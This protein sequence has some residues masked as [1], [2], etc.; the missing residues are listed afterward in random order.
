MGGTGPGQ[1]TP[2]APASDGTEA[3]AD[4]AA[5]GLDTTLTWAELDELILARRAMSKDGREALRHLAQT[6]L[7]EVLGK[8]NGLTLSDAAVAAQ[9]DEIKRQIVASGEKG[10]FEGFLK[11]K[12]VTLVDFMRLLR[13]GS[14][15]ETLT[16]RALGLKDDERVTG[17]QQQMWMDDALQ[18]RNYQEF[19]PP[20][21]DGIV[22]QCADVVIMQDEFFDYLHLRLPEEAL[23][24]D[25]WQLL[26]AKRMRARMPD[27][28][29]EKLAKAV[30]DELQR[31]RDETKLDPRVPFPPWAALV[32]L[33]LEEP[34]AFQATT[35][36]ARTT[37]R[38]TAMALR[39]G[40]V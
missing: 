11:S 37:T 14:V 24:E 12:R 3:A 8:Q 28:A 36:S 9:L 13:L 39:T 7:L 18:K 20:W 30:E 6:K 35:T 10:G 22:A 17:E 31:R 15:Q 19:N 2:K 4:I 38:P 27:L 23:K 26:A 21:K 34:Q 5:H 29:P 25:C 16:R 1:S 40:G 33:L 32:L